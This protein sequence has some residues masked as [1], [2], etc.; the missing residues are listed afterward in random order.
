M[1]LF[2]YIV[3]VKARS[4]LKGS[5][6]GAVSLPSFVTGIIQQPDKLHFF[7]LKLTAHC[8]SFSLG[9]YCKRRRNHSSVILLLVLCCPSV[10]LFA[11]RLVQTRKVGGHV[12]EPVKDFDRPSKIFHHS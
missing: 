3:N 8:H 12:T 10:H 11:E 6:A 9:E 1:Q 2:P 5:H 4:D 7:V